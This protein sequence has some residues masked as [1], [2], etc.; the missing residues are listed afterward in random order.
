[1]AR[2]V[3]NGA[4]PEE[5]LVSAHMIARLMPRILSE[6]EGATG[7]WA[8]TERES[9]EYRQ[10]LE[11]NT[12][13][14]LLKAALRE[15]A[16]EH[17]NTVSPPGRRHVAGEPVQ[18]VRIDSLLEP[19][20]GMMLAIGPDR[21]GRDLLS[22]LISELVDDGTLPPWLDIPVEDLSLFGPR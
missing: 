20:L 3:A 12:A 13:E 21:P 1:M 16:L 19:H 10:I 6:E 2:T 17:I 22:R 18:R 4:T 9:R 11:K 14:M 8:E 15:L 7:G 5:E